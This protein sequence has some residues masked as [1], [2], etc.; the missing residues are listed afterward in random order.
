MELVTLNK[1]AF[2]HCILAGQHRQ[3]ESI[4]KG[5][6][7]AYGFDGKNGVQMHILGVCGEY[8]V[9]EYFNLPYDFHV[10][11]FKEGSDVG[12]FQVRTRSRE[13]YDLLIRPNDDSN[14]IFILVTGTVGTTPPTMKI[15]GW[16][17]ASE[18]KQQKF[19][20]TYG[21]RT[22]AYFVPK[23]ELYQNLE[24]IKNAYVTAYESVE[25]AVFRA[26]I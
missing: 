26:Q 2:E 6:K 8:A 20:Q 21:G 4:K 10:N 17:P 19:K 22:P 13:D 9:A 12:P 1:F 5:L 23:H 24:E 18:A 7:D 15:W 11:K 16:L 25:E 3:E 14:K